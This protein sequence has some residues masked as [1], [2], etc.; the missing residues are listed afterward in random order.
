VR[1]PESD[2]QPSFSYEPVGLLDL[3]PGHRGYGSDQKIPMQASIE[4]YNASVLEA[5]TMHGRLPSNDAF[6]SRL[7]EMSKEATQ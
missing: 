6:G 4:E 1:W 5:Q 3:P 7:H 2:D